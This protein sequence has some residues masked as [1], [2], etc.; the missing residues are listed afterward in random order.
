MAS[1]HHE[2]K[3]GKKGTAQEHSIYIARQGRHKRRTDLVFSGYG[4]MPC[5]ANEDPT[6]FWNTADE[7]ER[8]NAA[9]YREHV[10]AL[11]NEL[12]RPAL[13]EVIG[14]FVK[15]LVG[16]KPYQFAV[17]APK[18]A[19]EGVTNTHLH[20]MFSDRM[21]DGIDRPPAQIFKRY[22]AKNPKLGGWKKD[23]G[24]KERLD[25]RD[26]MIAMRRKC[27][28]VQNAVLEKHGHASRVDYRTLKQQGIHRTAETHLGHAAIKMMTK[29]EKE[30]YRAPRL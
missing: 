30:S 18:S 11:P 4:N 13:E 14:D 9:V 15:E 26:Q 1:F 22:N 8:K 10:T 3:S 20:L 27:A 16:S 2:L 29:E 28:E 23:S 7:H 21:D 5:W 19:L 17:H 6:V 25:L 24:G 12:S